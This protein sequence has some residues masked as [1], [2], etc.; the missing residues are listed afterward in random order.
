MSHTLN[1][2]LSSMQ[3]EPGCQLHAVHPSQKRGGVDSKAGTEPRFISAHKNLFK[4]PN[5]LVKPD[6]PNALGVRYQL[7]YKPIFLQ[8]PGFPT[9]VPQIY[10]SQEKNLMYSLY[11]MLCQLPAKLCKLV[12]VCMREEIHSLLLKTKMTIGFKIQS[13][14]DL[15]LSASG[16]NKIVLSS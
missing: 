3:F 15:I 4:Q 10:N 16:T 12:N 8:Q 2:I 6:W 7:P 13:V 5:T 14:T 1:I 11:N 9:T